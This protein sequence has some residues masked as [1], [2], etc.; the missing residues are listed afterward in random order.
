MPWVLRARNLRSAR[1]IANEWY[2]ATGDELIPVFVGMDLRVSVGT[3]WIDEYETST[4]V[5]QQDVFG[6]VPST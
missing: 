6:L 5:A 4:R 3:K 2:D 1:Y